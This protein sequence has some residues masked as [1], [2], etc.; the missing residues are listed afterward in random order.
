MKQNGN[1]YLIALDMDGTLLNSDHQICLKTKDYL[2]NLSAQGHKI[3]ISSGRPLRGLISVY[4]ELN[5]ST[6]AICYNGAYIYQGKESSFPE[7]RFAFPKDRILHLIED[8]GYECLDNVILETNNDIYLLHNDDALDIFFS[9]DHMRVHIGPIENN[10][11]EDPMTM[12]IKVR[13]PIY[14]AQVQSAVDRYPEL[15]LRFWSGK[16]TEISE[17]YF[18]TVDKAKALEKI[19]VFYH[20]PRDRI[21]AFGDACNDIG[22]LKFAGIGV[23]MKNAEDEVKT[24][25]DRIA[26]H[27]NDE[28]GILHELEEIFAIDKKRR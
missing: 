18:P 11:D 28:D 25:A 13:D 4:R 10:L 27:T 8:I 2:R 26:S 7:Y 9:K 3:I 17:I 20:I 19:A 24:I 12:L 6:P 22:L 1:K 16:W 14:N 23:A 15:R 5:L 21:I